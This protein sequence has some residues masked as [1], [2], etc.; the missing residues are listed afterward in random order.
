MPVMLSLLVLKT[1]QLNRLKYFYETLGMEFQPEQHG[2]GPV[3]FSA[4]LGGMVLE[5]YPLP[6]G[7]ADRTTRLGFIV[8]EVG[9]LAESLWRRELA[10]LTKVKE[11]PWGRCLI[12]KDPDG[13]TVELYQAP[14][15]Q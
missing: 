3:H 5:I 13:R 8:D 14:R 7:E 4:P 6:E 15:Q 9:S 12:V 11:T 1:E 2:N 10:P